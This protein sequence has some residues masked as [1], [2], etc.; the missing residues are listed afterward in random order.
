VQFP[1]FS[2]AVDVDMV[3]QEKKI[4]LVLSPSFCTRHRNLTKDKKKKESL[5]EETER[6]HVKHF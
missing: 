6:D 2:A 5:S 1:A 3:K 4:I